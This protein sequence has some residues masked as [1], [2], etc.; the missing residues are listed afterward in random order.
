VFSA[1]FNPKIKNFLSIS[2]NEIPVEYWVYRL[3]PPK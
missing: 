1:L 2:Y 3:L